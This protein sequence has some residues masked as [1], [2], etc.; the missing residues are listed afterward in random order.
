M[1]PGAGYKAR[2]R[3][4]LV[5]SLTLALTT[6]C[7]PVAP[8]KAP[9]PR[10]TATPVTTAVQ[11]STSPAPAPPSASATPTA[12]AIPTPT[13][14]I[15]AAALAG[16]LR[17]PAKIISDNGGGVLSNNGASIIS[18]NG[19]GIVSNNGG[20]YRLSAAPTQLPVE[21]ASVSLVDAAGKVVATAITDAQG[22][23][24]FP[25]VP[26]DH[27]YLL[28][29]TLGKAG[30]LQAIVPP[31]SKTVDTDL[32]S[33]LTTGYILDQYVNIQADRV[34]VL[35]KLPADVEAKTRATAEAAFTALPD[36][37]TTA[38]VVAAV[39]DLRKANQA[40]DRQMEAVKKLLIVAGQSDLGNGQ[41][42]LEV[43]LPRVLRLLT[44]P[45][46]TLYIATPV[47]VWRLATDG[48]LVTAY[49]GTAVAD[50]KDAAM[51]AKG[52]LLVLD[53]N[54][55]QRRE[56]DGSVT[57][58]ATAPS[59][60]APGSKA[61]Q[62]GVKNLLLGLSAGTGD[63]VFVVTSEDRTSTLSFLSPR[64]PDRLYSIVPG[65]EPRVVRE[66]PISEQQRG[67]YTRA[68]DGTLYTTAGNVY[69]QALAPGDTKYH[70]L[71]TSFT[72][73]GVEGQLV[74]GGAI[75]PDGRIVTVE[76]D[77]LIL[78]DGASSRSLIKP[79]PKQLPQYGSGGMTAV[80]APDGS[81][82]VAGIIGMLF[83]AAA[84]QV[85][86]VK[87]GQATLV[88]GRTAKPPEQGQANA[89]A[90]KEPVALAP[91]PDGSLWVF[92]N[93]ELRRVGTDGLVT[94]LG[95]FPSN[96]GLS[97]TRL[98]V[99]PA[100]IAYSFAHGIIGGDTLY[101]LGLDGK[102][103]VV[104]QTGDAGTESYIDL[105]AL[106]DGTV[107]ALMCHFVK[108]GSYEYRFVNGTKV[109]PLGL[110]ESL[111]W[112]GPPFFGSS[113]AGDVYVGLAQEIRAVQADG[114]LA[115]FAAV[116][117]A[118]ADRFTVDARGRV[119]LSHGT[120]VER[121]DPVAKT[122]TPI[123]GPGTPRFA[124]SAVDDSLLGV[125][126]LAMT[127]DG[128]LLILDAGHKQIKRIPASELP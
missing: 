109:Q 46:G 11:A 24:S 116:G 78:H 108:D 118:T 58:V 96:F 111:H 92:D 103:S 98:A 114:S 74:A 26:A 47:R 128:T 87:D 77:A 13:P 95:S 43:D 53:G 45:D 94:S 112:D 39:N 123:A 79:V 83:N 8:V 15:A 57:L 104:S 69:A 18:D 100:G 51:D 84:W 16:T 25:S 28:T 7:G 85:L 12:L 10:A 35:D 81:L 71:Y 91:R 44:A 93:A 21:R 54:Q 48:T 59:M 22:R 31:G 61:E 90:L 23:Y 113:A 110:V 42:A 115:P 2:M 32:F 49:G 3:H 17:I 127:A 36:A 55:I 88:A 40:F 14:V 62:N 65:Q 82:Y 121:F 50:L 20:S 6:A 106:R 19:G 27:N 80:V 41:P 33:T 101:K 75:A 122:R 124:G 73:G 29:A 99:D 4:R 89:V 107:V 60:V 52:R 105:A 63:E 64:Q 117:V 34:K 125:N 5:L 76:D 119:Y 126:A 37:L 97:P 120:S 38:K 1:A 56:L 30:T 67:V 9:T 102:T 72:I 86:H 70:P 66:L 68:A